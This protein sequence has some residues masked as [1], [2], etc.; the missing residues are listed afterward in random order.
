MLLLCQQMR[1]REG[2]YRKGNSMSETK[3]NPI[4]KNMM[5]KYLEK[6][7]EIQ[8]RDLSNQFEYFTASL[9]LKNFAGARSDVDVD[10]YIA[11]DGIQGYDFFAVLVNDELMTDIVDLDDTLEKKE[12][13]R[14]KFIFGQMK[15]GQHIKLA[16]VSTFL[17]S[18]QRIISE[19]GEVDYHRYPCA[20]YVKSVYD[21]AEKFSANPELS[22]IYVVTGKAEIADPIKEK[23]LDA[24]EVISECSVDFL[25]AQPIQD[26][27]RVTEQGISR[28][29][30]IPGKTPIADVPEISDGYIGL[31]SLRELLN[32]ITLD[33]GEDDR[34]DKRR[35]AKSVFSENIRDYQ[36]HVEV[37]NSIFETLKDPEK[38]KRFP[39]LNNGITIVSREI[40]PTKEQLFL[41]QYQIV[42]GC[43]TAH[44]VHEFFSDLVDSDGYEE[45][46]SAVGK[47]HVMAKIVGTDNPDLLRAI[48]R[49]TNQQTRVS[50]ENLLANLPIQKNIEEFFDLKRH[51]NK[52]FALYYERRD[53]QWDR[54][55]IELGK[56]RIIS[57]RH[58][59]QAFGSCFL[60]RPHRANRYYT[61]LRDMA[62]SEVFDNEDKLPYLWVSALLF[63]R[64]E[65]LFSNQKISSDMKPIK[66][67]ILAAITRAFVK[68]NYKFK[69]SA[70]KAENLLSRLV[71]LASD[72]DSYVKAIEIVGE[73]AKRKSKDDKITRDFC[74]AEGDVKNFIREAS[75]AV[76]K[77]FN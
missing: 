69:I 60:S 62:E 71:E 30:N 45:A 39:V 17:D 55:H 75:A 44:V 56:W 15:G 13:I 29:V 59:I 42:N 40:R 63:C 2:L 9:I 72:D 23:E 41:K 50:P 11:G 18:V 73:L 32:L 35:L 16:P 46:Y 65:F 67:H 34:L 43:Q 74:K 19:V 37:N 14:I 57:I 51:D 12:N 3:M 5:K 10:E 53:K 68:G 47:I 24:L 36:G 8:N 21:N 6:L 76:R 25:G 1:G 20:E 54:E 64:M 38:R 52:N 70:E 77:E 48:T 22:C 66:F 58:L 61:D 49:A 33:G 7:P 31:I 28:R 26:L 27:Y 4:V